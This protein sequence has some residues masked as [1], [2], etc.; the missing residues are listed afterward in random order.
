[1]EGIWCLLL[2]LESESPLGKGHGSA[3]DWQVGSVQRL[4]LWGCTRICCGDPFGGC[5]LHFGTF[6]RNPRNGAAPRPSQLPIC[7]PIWACLPQLPTPGSMPLSSPLIR[8]SLSWSYAL[9]ALPIWLLV[10]TGYCMFSLGHI[11]ETINVKKN[12]EGWQFC[13][14]ITGTSFPVPMVDSASWS[15]TPYC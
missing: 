2:T 14:K 1:M 6:P 8:K 7:T 12:F 9:R 5:Y 15:Q 13:S 10:I 11:V 4:K 3:V